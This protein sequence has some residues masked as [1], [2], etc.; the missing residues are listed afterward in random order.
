LT[1]SAVMEGEIVLSPAARP[2]L[3]RPTRYEAFHISHDTNRTYPV[4]LDVVVSYTR[5]LQ[6]RE[7]PCPAPATLQEAIDRA[8]ATSAFNHKDKLAIKA[9]DATTSKITL[10]LYAVKRKSA[11]DYVW[12]DHVQYR[13]HRLYVDPVCAL[14][15][16]VLAGDHA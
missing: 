7:V 11:P 2:G 14:D 6:R 8:L 13:E 3:Y 16:A 12:R 15:W 10:H 1:D 5:D 9:T 4:R